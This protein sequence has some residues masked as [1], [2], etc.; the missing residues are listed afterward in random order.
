MSYTT[1]GKKN[2]ALKIFL[3]FVAG[4]LGY[5]LLEVLFR[6]HSHWTM[7]LC[8]GICLVGMYYIN[9]KLAHFSLAVRALMCTALITAVEFTA[10]CAVNLWLGWNVWSYKSLP[11][12]F[13]G[14]ISLLFCCYWF[15]LSFV[16]CF[17]IS[18]IERKI[19]KKSKKKELSETTP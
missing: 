18:F 10:G 12:N 15:L 16:V 3:L 9:K 8:G 6:G 14:Q 1:Y 13:M 5:Y 17:L 4:G 19:V 11:L 7:G 2:T